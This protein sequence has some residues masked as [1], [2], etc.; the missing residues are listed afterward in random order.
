MVTHHK[1]TV[2]TSNYTLQKLVSLWLNMFINFSNIPLRISFFIGVILT[3]FGLALITFF[4]IDMMFINPEGEWPAG[5]ASLFVC[6][7]TFSGTQLISLGLIGE[8]LGKL[9]LTTNGTPQFVVR[10]TYSSSLKSPKTFNKNHGV[11]MEKENSG[12]KIY[13]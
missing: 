12:P 6:I 11:L 5:W 8:Y 4:V 2:G 13:E 7:L 9:Y 3:L 10:E 1:R